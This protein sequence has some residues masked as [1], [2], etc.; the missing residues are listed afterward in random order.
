M[1]ALEN[2]IFK[3]R[4]TNQ[5][6]NALRI[7]SV[8]LK[9]FRNRDFPHHR[10]VKFL[11]DHYKPI[12][13]LFNID[14][15]FKNLPN[16]HL[17]RENLPSMEELMLGT[18]W[19]KNISKIIGLPKKSR[20]WRVKADFI[21][22]RCLEKFSS[23]CAGDFAN[24]KHKVRK[25]KESIKAM[26]TFLNKTSLAVAFDILQKEDASL[27][28]ERI[29]EWIRVAKCLLVRSKDYHSASG[30]VAG[31]TLSSIYRL[32]RSWEFAKDGLMLREVQDMLRNNN[33]SHQRAALH[34]S[35]DQAKDEYGEIYE[36]MEKLY[37]NVQN[38]EQK[39]GSYEELDRMADEHVKIERGKML[40][41]QS[42]RSKLITSTLMNVLTWGSIWFMFW[43][44]INNTKR[45][46]YI[47]HLVCFFSA[48]LISVWVTH[49]T[50]F[51]EE[52]DADLDNQNEDNE[53]NK[54]CTS[55]RVTTYLFDSVGLGIL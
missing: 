14:E 50:K 35:F 6:L 47:S 48:N 11:D 29:D 26:T 15:D 55:A 16:F 28:G 44:Y 10:M 2:V 27:R 4:G 13:E 22:V 42:V 8:W 30:V 32:K 7:L 51:E 45:A 46:Y 49:N 25:N 31:L 1:G 12:L 17:I 24:C 33:Y 23:L 9:N 40:C 20:E 18:K 53:E 43:V 34:K 37:E 41:N 21:Y 52:E 39:S 38:I 36:E 54:C 3:A 5:K 19:S